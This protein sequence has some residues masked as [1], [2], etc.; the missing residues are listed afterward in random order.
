MKISGQERSAA[1]GERGGHARK[2]RAPRGEGR[3]LRRIGGV[4][5][6]V[7]AREMA[8]HEAQVDFAREGGIARQSLGLGERKAEARHAAVEL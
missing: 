7:A 8:H 4:I 3:K 1:V 6:L 5:G 2:Q